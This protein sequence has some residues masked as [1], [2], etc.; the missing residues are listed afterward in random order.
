M[1]I[2]LIGGIDRLVAEYMDIA[3][4]MG[5]KLK[6]ITKLSKDMDKK[7]VGADRVIVFTDKISHK[8]KNIAVKTAKSKNIPIF[9]CHSSG[10]CSLKNCI[11]CILSRENLNFYNVK[12]K[13]K[14][15]MV[16]KLYKK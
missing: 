5:I 14:S 2:V 7:I 1:S 13:Q 3:K 10:V 6:V 15:K 9:F 16:V 4:D 11:N 12:E 8:A